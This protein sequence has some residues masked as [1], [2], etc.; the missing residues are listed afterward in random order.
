M[1]IA[2][3]MFFLLAAL[4]IFNPTGK[5]AVTARA[6]ENAAIAGNM[7]AYH[8]AA[9]AQ[10]SAAACAT[11]AITPTKLPTGVVNKSGTVADN[12]QAG[13]VSGV[14]PA[15]QS[16]FTF[17]PKG[18]PFVSVY[19]GAGHVIT[20]WN[21][22]NSTKTSFNGQ[23]ATALRRVSQASDG[24]GQ[25]VAASGTISLG[26]PM[27]ACTNGAVANGQQVALDVACPRPLT[28]G[29][30]SNQSVISVPA[31]VGGVTLVDQQPIL[32]TQIN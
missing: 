4:A 30:T 20:V 29:A 5:V 25:Y 19:D 15:A 10:C 13:A 28:L 3:F 17:F 2:F 8:R 31:T 23:V 21:A 9:V 22:P 24:A 32:Y 14:V 12:S 1:Q 7:L 26:H 11:G 16:S 18:A 6:D 27:A